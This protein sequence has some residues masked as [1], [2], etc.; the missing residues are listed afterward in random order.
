GEMKAFRQGAQEKVR[1]LA[2]EEKKTIANI[3][4][5]NKRLWSGLS[6]SDREQIITNVVNIL[7]TQPVQSR[8]RVAMYA[9]AAIPQEYA[10]LNDALRSAIADDRRRNYFKPP[11]ASQA[12]GLAFNP[13][14]GRAAAMITGSSGCGTR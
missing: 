3:S 1:A 10:S 11:G 13:H 5:E 4:E 8:L 14:D 2:D 12:W 6:E 9:V 7:S